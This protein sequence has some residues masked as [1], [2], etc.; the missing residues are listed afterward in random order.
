MMLHG[1]CRVK[2]REWRRRSE[3][4][5]NHENLLPSPSARHSLDLEG[6]VGAA[7]VQVVTQTANYKR[8]ALELAEHLPPLRRREDGEH[9]LR[10]VERVPPVVVGDVPVVLLHAQQ[11]A[12]E[13][14]VVDVEALDEVQVEEH[15]ETS[16]E[17][18][19]VIQVKVVE[20]E[21][22][23]LEVRRGWDFEALRKELSVSMPHVIIIKTSN[24][25]YH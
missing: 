12:A 6:I 7:V 11:P 23:K 16:F 13:H 15:P 8:K 17:R 2:L 18:S 4:E 24:K 3:G 21:V 19:V 9:H 22:V 10:D 5:K 1:G 25:I 14:L 20:C